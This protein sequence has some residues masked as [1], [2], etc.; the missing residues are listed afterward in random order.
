MNGQ[1]K[2]SWPRYLTINVLTAAVIV[3]AIYVVRNRQDAPEAAA[4]QATSAEIEPQNRIDEITYVQSIEPTGPGEYRITL[5]LKNNG[6]ARSNRLPNV[7]LD[8]LV[9]ENDNGRRVGR[10]LIPTAIYRA[11]EYAPDDANKEFVER[12]LPLDIQVPAGTQAIASC[13]S[14]GGLGDMKAAR[15]STKIDAELNRPTEGASN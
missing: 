9:I 2:S 3:A 13:L 15:C 6:D 1:D 8:F 4:P 11:S 5:K 10:R 7:L 14:Y 12:D